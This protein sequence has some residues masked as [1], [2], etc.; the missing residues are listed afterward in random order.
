MC[1]LIHVIA[2]YSLLVG[3]NSNAQVFLGT[4][5]GAVTDQSGAVIARAKIMVRNSDTGVALSGESNQ[6]GVYFIGELRPG[7]YQ[8]EA[9]A[10]GFTRFVQRGITLRVEDRLRIDVRLSV[11][12]VAEVVEVTA[13]APLVE[14]ESTTLGKVVEEQTIKQLP[15]SGRNA[16]ALANLVPGVQQRSGDEQPRLSGGRS[17]S[18]EFVMDGASITEPRRGEIQ[19][20]PNLDAIQEFKVQTNGLSAEFGRTM[21]GVI[22]ATLKSGTNQFHGNLFDF[23]R[24]DNLNAR[25]F[26]SS[27]VPKLVQNQFGGM[28]GGPIKRDRT[29]FFVDYEG[30]R[31]RAESNYNL[32]LPIPAFKRGDFSSVLGNAIGTDA[33]ERSVALNQIFDPG[34]TRRAANGR[35]VRDPFPGNVV[36]S[37]RFD[38]AGAK[39]VSLYVDPNMPGLSQNFR[40]LRPQGSS[41]NKFDVR[42]DHR[43]TDRNQFSSR[44]SLD[45]QEA[46][47]GRPYA[48]S[49]TGSSNANFNRYKTGVTNWTHTFTPTTLNDARISFFRGNLERI[50][51]PVNAQALGIPNLD[52]WG[53]PRFE[54]TGFDFIGDAQIFNPTQEQYQAQNIVTFVRG[55]HIIKTGADVRR[56]RVN[57]LQSGFNG[58]YFLSTLQTGDPS[59]AR[60][61]HVIASLLLGQIDQFQNQTGR[62]RFYH[63]S[64]YGGLFL[65]DDYKISPSFTLNAGVRYEV[66]QPPSEIRRNGSTFDLSRGRVLTLEELGRDRVQLTDRNKFAPR[67]GFAWRPFARRNTVVRSHYGIFYIPLTGR[68]TSAFA[69]F[70]KEQTV[71]AASDGINAA[72]ILSQTPALVASNDARGQNFLY[73]DQHAP[74]GY[75]QQWNFDVQQQLPGQV[76]FQA[77]YAAGKGSHFLLYTH[78]NNIPIEKVQAMGRG[79]QDMRPYPDFLDIYSHDE[80][81]NSNYQSLQLS[82]ERHFSK[83]LMFLVSYTLS[84]LID[85]TEDNFSQFFPIDAYNLRLEKCLSYVHFPHRLVA[86]AVYDLPFGKNRQLLRTGWAGKVAGGWQLGTIFVAQSGNQVWIQQPT[87]TSRTFSQQFRPN[88][89]ANPVLPPGERTIDRWF[90]TAVFQAPPPMTIGNS[91]RHPNIQGPG[92][93]DV[94]LSLIRFIPLKLT[95]KTKLELRAECFSCS[96]RPQFNEPNGQF[97]TT[98]FGRVTSAGGARVF[99]F[100]LKVWF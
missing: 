92:V 97:G 17:R 69:R 16:F 50:W 68:A 9:E 8:L 29:F 4:I 38:A 91:P 57:D 34:T 52:P 55:K 56:F 32:T 71:A 77:S 14:S 84:K 26:F 15:L 81:G 22:N 86:S 66:E 65:Q 49:S 3:L 37:G 75:Y 33:M 89:V 41:I 78:Y 42:I 45:N 62:N 80:R 25:N 73:K 61:G 79:T 100:A 6:A 39:I 53:L 74:T 35:Y 48:Y 54:T 82:A 23:L 90:N 83:G 5:Q 27:T 88:L 95:E 43:F 30:R 87:N 67:L 10:S 21:G 1:K 2:V 28:L 24:N 51:S 40:V 13:Q 47:A 59:N 64:S 99:Q 31:T 7:N 63:R 44:F 12:P 85:D 46:L 20:Q 72:F 60:T 70:P 18:G 98:N 58:R 94:D 19:T 93:A 11:G 36:P 76:R 96:N